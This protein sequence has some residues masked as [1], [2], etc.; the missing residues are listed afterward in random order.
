MRLLISVFVASRAISVFSIIT[1][2]DG[3]LNVIAATLPLEYVMVLL[4]LGRK[5]TRRKSVKNVAP[6]L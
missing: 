5:M 4:V 1:R 3:D 2:K 6:I